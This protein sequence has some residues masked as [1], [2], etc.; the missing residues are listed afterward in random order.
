MAATEARQILGVV[1]MATRP[2]V[3]AVAVL[4]ATVQPG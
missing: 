1:P 3:V 4:V 2:V